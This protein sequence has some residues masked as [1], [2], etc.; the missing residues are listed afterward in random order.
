MERLYELHSEGSFDMIVVDTPPSRNALDFIDAPERMVEFFSSRL[1]RWLIVP[2][3]SRALNAWTRPFYQIAD[4]ILGAQ[5]LADIAEFFILFQSMSDGFAERA[6]SVEHLVRDRRTA[7]V[8][9]TTLEFAPAQEAGH[10]VSA[11]ADRGYPLGALVLNRLLPG[12]VGDPALSRLAEK[13]IGRAGVLAQRLAELVGGEAEQVSRVLGEV[14]HNFRN[15]SVVAHREA[16]VREQLSALPEVVVT[17]PEHE[18][19]IADLTG[20]LRLGEKIW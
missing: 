19:D 13:L 4:R 10:L 20:L 2:Y 6:R 17:V 14:G 9:V 1:L 5:F 15:L 7:F 16:A 18:A 11:L 3:R 8:V 12:Y